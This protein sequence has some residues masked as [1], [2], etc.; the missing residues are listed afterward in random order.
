M[1]IVREELIDKFADF[2]SELL[3][4][5]IDTDGNDNFYEL[6]NLLEDNIEK[7]I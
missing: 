5:E 1:I 6:V 2:L 3:G 4:R 7:G